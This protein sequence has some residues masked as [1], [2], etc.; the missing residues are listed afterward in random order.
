MTKNKKII[1]FII[2]IGALVAILATVL[3]FTLVYVP[4]TDAY[5]DYTVADPNL[6][7]EKTGRTLGKYTVQEDGVSVN[8][9]YKKINGED[10]K[11]IVGAWRRS[12][13]LFS[14]GKNL[15]LI[16]PDKSLDVFAD[17][18]I[19]EIELFLV[20]SESDEWDREYTEHEPSDIK[21]ISVAKTQD[22]G[23]VEGFLSI[24]GNADEMPRLADEY[25]SELPPARDGASRPAY[26]GIRIHFEESDGIVWES[27]MSI[28][29]SG[30]DRRIFLNILSVD[31]PKSEKVIEIPRD[32]ELFSFIVKE[33]FG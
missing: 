19:S 25:S 6:T 9:N 1:A 28:Y 20:D 17:W 11:Q 22:A 2:L 5:A 15:V 24:I 10:E 16:S 8:Y 13:A 26:C 18:K 4:Q 31:S 30:K 23:A 27:E 12:E 14:Y 7:W 33:I 3:Y 32:G 21:R 29:Y